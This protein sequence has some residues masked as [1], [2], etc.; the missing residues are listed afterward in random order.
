MNKSREERLVEAALSLFGERGY[1]GASVS[2]IAARAGVAKGLFYHYFESKQDL[3][4]RLAEMRLDEWSEL[5][6]LLEGGGEPRQRLEQLVDFLF[7]ELAQQPE[8]LRLLLG[9]YLTEDGV[10][11]IAEA[12]D[13]SS[14]RFCQLEGA[15]EQLFVDLGWPTEE[16]IF[17]RSLVQGISLE[18]LLDPI[19][20]PLALMRAEL[21]R[22]YL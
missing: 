10:A 17:F 19:H 6:E 20:Y 5:I 21:L 3:L 7:R 13:R 9:V 8:R 11:A 4:V 14:D 15:Q 18:Y 16:S 1:H 12:M 2:Q 22:R